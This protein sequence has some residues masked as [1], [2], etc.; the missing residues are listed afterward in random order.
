MFIPLAPTAPFLSY[1]LLT[2]SNSHGPRIKLTWSRPTEANGII[3]NYTVFYSHH[4]DTKE[5]SFGQNV[6]SSI[7]DVLGGV[8]YQ[9]HVQA[10]T[11][12]PGPNASFTVTIP[13]YGRFSLNFNLSL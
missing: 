5:K 2:P 4:G 13:E 10:V 7:L 9:F 12:K 3:R 6:L 11:I 8:S 1:T